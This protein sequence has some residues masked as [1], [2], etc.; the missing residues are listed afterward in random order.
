MTIDNQPMTTKPSTRA[1]HQWG[2]AQCPPQHPTMTIM[3]ASS[4]RCNNEH[5]LPMGSTST[6]MTTGM[7]WQLSMTHGPQ[8]WRRTH[9]QMAQ[10]RNGSRRCTMG[11]GMTETTRTTRWVVLLVGDGRDRIDDNTCASC[12]RGFYFYLIKFMAPCSWHR[13]G[14]IFY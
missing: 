14:H 4:E 11:S 13:R 6:T 12:T 9:V 7:R 3:G 1:P 5:Q 2:M 8:Q 10:M